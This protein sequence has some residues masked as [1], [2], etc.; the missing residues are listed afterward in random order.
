MQ[1]FGATTVARWLSE[2]LPEGVRSY[3][4][5]CGTLHEMVSIEGRGGCLLPRLRV[6]GM[7]RML[8]VPRATRL[9]MATPVILSVEEDL[10]GKTLGSICSQ[11][12]RAALGSH[13]LPRNG[14]CCRATV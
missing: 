2:E 6:R 7:L 9:A 10:A 13:A 5:A 8:H 11:I 12:G 4:E 1:R 14:V 3:I